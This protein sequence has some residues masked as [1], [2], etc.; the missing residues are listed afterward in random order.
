MLTESSID[1]VVSE[2]VDFSD[3]AVGRAKMFAHCHTIYR[4][5][6]SKKSVADQWDDELR[7]V[8]GKAETLENEASVA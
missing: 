2:L 3:A 7:G 4:L 8:L 6:F 1:E 5:Y